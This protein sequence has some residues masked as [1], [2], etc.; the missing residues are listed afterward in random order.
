[1]CNVYYLYVMC[2]FF[3]SA[4]ISISPA[5]DIPLTI[6]SDANVTYTCV[7][8]SGR[9]V[10]WE[11]QNIQLVDNFIIENFRD[12]G[13]FIESGATSSTSSVIITEMARSNFFRQMVTEVSVQCNAFSAGP[14]PMVDEGQT[15]MVIIYG[16]LY[17]CV[18]VDGF[19]CV[20]MWFMF[21]MILID[22]IKLHRV[23]SFYLVSVVP[24]SEP[25]IFHVDSV[26]ATWADVCWQIP[27]NIG[28][29]AVSRYEVVAMDNSTGLEIEPVSTEGNDT[30][31]NVTGLLPGTVYV[32]SVRAISEVKVE[33]GDDVIGR[34]GLS[35]TDIATTG[36]TGKHTVYI[37][38]CC[39][40]FE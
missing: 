6:N 32:M 16:R 38:T 8:D 12:I 13:V 4:F 36:V 21:C 3:S 29:P 40:K 31:L 34:S 39:Q 22:S 5:N 28:S 7:V 37:I 1:M 27:E 10:L 26:G 30:Q 20:W 2:V 35:N 33:L 14:P 24:S 11:L 9:S 19:A 15:Y 17:V 23:P 18:C 25:R